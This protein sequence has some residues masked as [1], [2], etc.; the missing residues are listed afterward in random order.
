MTPHVEN[1]LADVR[2]SRGISAAQLAA[3][4]G[5]RRQ[6]IHAIEAGTYLPNTG[7]ALALADALGVSIDRL[8]T[9]RARPARGPRTVSARVIRS[10][11]PPQSPL[12]RVCRVGGGWVGIPI[13]AG[14]YHL[15][16]ADGV[17][18]AAD[19][20]GR[21]SIT[22]L[23][24]PPDASEPL[25]IA[26]CD[27]AAMLL[28]RLVERVSGVRVLPVPAS[29]RQALALLEDGSVHLAG[30]HL[31]DAD[32]GEFNLPFVRRDLVEGGVTIVTLARWEAGW[33]VAAGNPKTIRAPE[34]LAQPGLTLVNREPGSGSRAL[35]MKLLK[36]AGVPPRAV[37]GFR[38]VERGHLAAAYRVASG[39][40]DVCLS[41]RAAAASFGLGFVPVQCERYD[42]VVPTTSCGL[43]QVETLLNVLQNAAVRREFA[44]VSGYD[45]GEMGR[46]VI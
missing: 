27:P 16:E 43:P 38:H 11:V 2:R 31:E 12:V 23:D 18:T 21:S 42:L 28:A 8:F 36:R 7:L 17:V 45:T 20:D 25:A 33:V 15:P 19:R 10:A 41:T 30:T 1:R 26:G 5:V 32:S 40:A 14:P 9:L 29:S 37:R 44:T 24:R 46:R 39:E 4:V 3:T 13:N 6:T 34:D 35:L 22:M